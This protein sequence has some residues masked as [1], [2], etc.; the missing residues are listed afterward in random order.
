MLV[1]LHRIV[2]ESDNFD[3]AGA[4]DSIEQDMARV[5]AELLDGVA[6]DPRATSSDGPTARIR[7]DGSESVADEVAVLANPGLAPAVAR[8]PQDGR[9]V[10]EAFASLF[11][12][13]GRW[14]GG[15]SSSIGSSRPPSSASRRGST[16]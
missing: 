9:D 8:V 12:A 13:S 14:F 10:A 1:E 11:S 4:G 3:G 15:T 6:E 7:G 2:E 5:P 16:R